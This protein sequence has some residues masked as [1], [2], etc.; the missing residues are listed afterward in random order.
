MNKFN[1]LRPIM[2]I[3]I[4]LLTKSLVTNLCMVLGMKSEA[5]QNMG[6]IAMLIAGLVVF[7]RIRK[8]QKK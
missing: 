1:I 3:A 6:Y 7:S 5:A 4:A 2:L 8:N